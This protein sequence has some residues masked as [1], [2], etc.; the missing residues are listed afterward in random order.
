MM[1][2]LTREQALKLAVRQQVPDKSRQK[3]EHVLLLTCI[4]CSAE[5]VIYETNVEVMQA[6]ETVTS[7]C[8]DL[9]WYKSPIGYICSG[10]IEDE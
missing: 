4:S 3:P 8:G 10:C 6:R 9:E 2:T 7:G 5:G 1:K